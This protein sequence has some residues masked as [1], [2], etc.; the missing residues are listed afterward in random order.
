MAP[1]EQVKTPQKCTK[2]EQIQQTS[3]K[4]HT[5]TGY[6]GHH[7]LCLLVSARDEADLLAGTRDPWQAVTVPQGELDFDVDALRSLTADVA[8]P[9]PVVLVGL[10][11]VAYLVG[12]HWCVPLV[13]HTD[14]LPLRTRKR[15]FRGNRG[16]A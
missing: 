12:P 10:H 15:S 5:H 4:T 7:I 11:D 1:R 16:T 3:S 2:E 14:L 8:C 13:H 6:L 9:Q